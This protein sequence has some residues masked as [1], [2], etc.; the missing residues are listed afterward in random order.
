MLQGRL[1]VFEFINQLLK[2]GNNFYTHYLIETFKSKF[3]QSWLG[4]GEMS[5]LISCEHSHF[6]TKKISN[7]QKKKKKALCTGL[8]ITVISK[9][10]WEAVEMYNNRKI[11]KM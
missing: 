4:Y 10:N 6:L 7:L 5:T 1:E 11:N 9:Y 2:V 3:N 8:L